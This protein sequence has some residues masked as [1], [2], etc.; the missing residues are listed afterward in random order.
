MAHTPIF[1]GWGTGGGGN[2]VGFLCPQGDP[3]SLA[4]TSIVWAE[5]AWYCWSV[6]V[7]ARE[8][9]ELPHIE[10]G[11]GQRTKKDIG[12]DCNRDA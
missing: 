6:D 1:S 2:G 10:V 8:R 5:E 11:E 9:G 4:L 7:H 3:V 12:R